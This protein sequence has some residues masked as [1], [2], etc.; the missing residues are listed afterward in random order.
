MPPTEPR[1]S[2]ET[3]PRLGVVTFAL[4]AA[5]G[6]DS[7]AP[8]ALADAGPVACTGGRSEVDLAA[9][10][11]ASACADVY[12]AAL[13][14]NPLACSTARSV[15]TATCGAIRVVFTLCGSTHGVYCAYGPSGGL[16]GQIAADDS[17]RFCRS[18]S[19]C[20]QYGDTGPGVACRNGDVVRSCEFSPP[21]AG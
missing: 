9:Y 10:Q 18:R 13:R 11:T 20:I 8:G 5:M 16:V 6:C 1:R 3:S 19:S 15:T 12:E 14:N 7:D 4:A 2:I 17:A 21:D